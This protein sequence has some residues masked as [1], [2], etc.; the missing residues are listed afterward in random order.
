MLFKIINEE[1]ISDRN[2]TPKEV[3]IGLIAVLIVFILCNYVL[4]LHW[5]VTLSICIIY[6]TSFDKGLQS[7]F[8][9]LADQNDEQTPEV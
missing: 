7:V 9:R 4:K 2:A 8:P 5:A 1:C 3:V 6:T